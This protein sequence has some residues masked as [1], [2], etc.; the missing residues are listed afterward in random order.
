MSLVGEKGEV[1]DTKGREEKEDQQGREDDGAED[2]EFI[3]LVK[4]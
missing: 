1:K 3:R 4:L 2:C